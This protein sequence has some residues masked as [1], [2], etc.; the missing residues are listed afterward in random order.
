MYNPYL[1]SRIAND[2]ICDLMKDRRFW[3]SICECVW[4]VLRRSG[5]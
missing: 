5:R 3:H 1:L 4:S 2:R